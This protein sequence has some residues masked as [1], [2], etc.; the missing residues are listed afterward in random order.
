[1]A[2]TLGLLIL[3]AATALIVPIINYLS[4]AEMRLRQL[5]ADTSRTIKETYRPLFTLAAAIAVLLP[6]LA[7]VAV[8]PQGVKA[9]FIPS[10]IALS[11]LIVTLALMAS[12]TAA[13]L[14]LRTTP[15]AAYTLVG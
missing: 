10:A 6:L 15:Q 4:N 11:G 2:T 7:N 9:I 8:F 5:P 14:E 1:M 13:R 12:D 3:I